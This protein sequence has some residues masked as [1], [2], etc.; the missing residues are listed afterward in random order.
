MDSIFD[1]GDP[2][3]FLGEDTAAET[4]EAPPAPAEPVDGEESEEASNEPKTHRDL[5]RG[6]LQELVDL[7]TE[8]AAHE[9]E[10]E[11]QLQSSLS[12]TQGT[13]QKKLS[14][15]ERKYKSLQEQVA[16]KV[17]EKQSQIEERYEKSVATLKSHDQNLRNRVRAEH[18]AAQQQIKKDY[19]QAT[20]L[21]ESV[22]EAEEG[23]AAEELKKA[24]ELNAAQTEYLNEKEGQA[25]AL[26]Q[27]FGQKPPPGEALA[28]IKEA[29]ATV[30]PETS[31]NQ[32]KEVMEQKTAALAAL[33]VPRLFVGA[34]PYLIGALVLAVAAAIP[35]AIKQTLEPQWQGLA[36]WVGAGIAGLIV[37]LVFMNSLA[38]KQIAAVYVPLRR[39]MDAGRIANDNLL[40]QATVEHDMNLA[41]ARR[42]N[43][44]ELQAA[45]DRAAPI[46][47]KATKRRDATLQTAQAELQAKLAQNELLRKSTLAELEQWRVR[48]LEEV[49]K[50]FDAE[51]AKVGDRATALT[52]ELRQKHAAERAVLEKR[53]AEGLKSIQEPIREEG[54]ANVAW[55]DPIWDDWKGP[56][57]FPATIRFGQLQVDLK[58]MVAEV[59]KEA[60]FTLPLPETFSVPA[61][62][63]YPKQ[64]SIMIHTDRP[65]RMDSIQA[66]QMIMT[67]LLTTIP[68]GR[69]RFTMIDPVGLGQN[70]AGFMHLADYDEALVGGRIWTDGEQIDQRLANLTEHMETVI[71][72]YLR[73]EFATIDD[74]NAQA[75]EL[76]EPYR[77]LVISDFPVNFS[78]EA[79]RRL[80]SIASTGSRCGVYTLVM[81]DTRVSTAGGGAMHLDDLEAHSVNLVREGDRFVWRDPVFN[82]FPLSLDQAPTDEELSKILHIVGK[83]AREAKRVEVSFDV[84]APK[85]PMFWTLKSDEDVAVAVGRSGA[86]RLQTF[87]LGRGVAQHALIAGKTGSGKSTLLHALITNLAMWYSPD[88]VELYLIDF[89]KGVEFK[90]YAMHHLPHARAIAVESDREF[91][92]SV[93]HRI[94]QEMTRRSELFRPLKSQNLQM[95]REASG[96]DMPRTLLIIDE[97]Q[98]FFTED[99]KLAQD[100][101]SLLERI[102]R[103]GRAFGVHLLLGSQ[104]IGGSS[105]LSRATIGQIGVRIALQTSEADSQMILGDGNSA[106]R[107]LSRPGE[108]IYNDAGGLVEGNSPFQVAW[109]PDEQRDRYLDQ[110]NAKLAQVGEKIDPP[111]VFEG[112][113]PADFRQNPL[114]VE[115]LNA[116]K[117][118]VSNAAPTVW[119][120]DPVAIKAPTAIPFRRQSGA[121]ILIVGQNEEGA[122]AISALSMIGLAAQLSPTSASFYLLDGT[123]ADAQNHGFLASVAATMPHRTKNVDYRAVPQAIHEIAAELV[124]RQAN[125]SSNP[126]SIFIVIFGLQRYRALRKSEES[127]NF[128]SS[129]GEK[130]PDPGKEFADVMRDGP[131]NGIHILAWIDT[132]TALERSVDRASMRELDNRILFQMSATDS[133]NLIDSPA[134]NKLGA[135][136]A[137]AYSEEQGSMEKF[138]PYA[139][140]NEKWLAEVKQTLVAKSQSSGIQPGEF[141]PDPAEAVAAEAAEKAKAAEEPDES[142]SEPPADSDDDKNAA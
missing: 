52:A 83:G 118:V 9:A 95:Y 110:V 85:L 113:E 55:S 24:T 63:A 88:E 39:A 20:W 106:A 26:M 109:L 137:L 81:R 97:F 108:A 107:L 82:R 1:Q 75:G 58:S 16:A 117:Y 47:D 99:D 111:I 61:L 53:W 30:D 80:S 136:R 69:V 35:Q 119:V 125:E 138:R 115:Q 62:M 66:M 59:A 98:E 12:Q 70:F 122:L 92:L 2:L 90:T 71:Q 27:R 103:Q 133:S 68:P 49:K 37:F 10:V 54:N 22:M 139:L 33:S 21:A 100:A 102:V 130:G 25:A 132:A 93:L 114:L 29:E 42:Q 65:G 89:K 112:N 79:M 15:A 60:P 76:A 6:A 45:R 123:P 67:R 19:D 105:G 46:L 36:I 142:E 44:G 127:F 38:K 50:L 34:T 96:K 77:Y 86:T 73:N 94:D 43:K 128:S 11:Q 23:K 4:P 131:A 13:G 3:S 140:P 8:C 126:P 101:N 129:E 74:Y 78:D 41:K 51:T 121:N 32:H 28:V 14:D 116:P 135:N 40:S 72:K 57:K 64:A 18:E 120:G 104:T 84:I 141:P 56:K 48:K 5:Q 124:R 7:V 91:G 134:A 31:F 17:H 87:R